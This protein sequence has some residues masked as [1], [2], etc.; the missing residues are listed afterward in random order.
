ME[1]QYYLLDV[2]TSRAFGGNQLAVFTDGAAIDGT[3]MAAIA[4]ELNL[5]ETVFILPPRDPRASHRL[6]IFT[7]GMELPFAGHPTIGTGYLLADLGLIARTNGAGACVFE[8]G[9]GPVPVTIAPRGATPIFVQMSP[10]RLPERRDAEVSR[11]DLA[12]ML[13]LTPADLGTGTDTPAA[14]SAGLAF[15]VVPLTSR[16]ALQ[17]ARIDTSVW[18]RVAAETWAPHIYLCH[19]DEAAASPLLH[20]RMFAPAMGIVE[21]PATGAAACAVAGYLASLG[22]GISGTTTWK[23]E[24]GAEMGRPSELWVDIDTRAGAI[25]AVRLGGTAVRVGRG[26]FTLT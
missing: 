4:R 5:S 15:L 21:D 23:I 26:F 1:H 14:W 12:P 6:R 13:N 20:A 2:F 17:R 19:R 10:A 25:A 24:Q 8:E 16:E 11:A 22:P 3:Q 9:V 7:P 18:K